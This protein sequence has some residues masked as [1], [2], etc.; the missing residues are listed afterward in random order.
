MADEHPD[1]RRLRFVMGS[2]DGFRNV[3][4]DRYE[5]AAM[6][7]AAAGGRDKPS[8][9]DELNGFRLLVDMAMNGGGQDGLNG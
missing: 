5:L 8:E 4:K 1:T 6:I 3:S 7:F 2:I 9:S